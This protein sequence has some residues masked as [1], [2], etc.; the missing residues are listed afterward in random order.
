MG[1]ARL[2]EEGQH[3][4]RHTFIGILFTAYPYRHTLSIVF[5]YQT[6]GFDCLSLSIGL[7]Y[8]T[9]KTDWV[10]LSIAFDYRQCIIDSQLLLGL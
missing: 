1:S 9:T 2:C 6:P 10:S 7:D 4:I 8:R 3:L 5:P